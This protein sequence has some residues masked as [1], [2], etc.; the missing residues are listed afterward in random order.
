[1]LY[2][3]QVYSELISNSVVEKCLKRPGL[4]RGTGK[5]VLE[6][7]RPQ[8]GSG[9][10]NSWFSVRITGNNGHGSKQTTYLYGND[11]AQL[12]SAKGFLQ[13][14][15]LGTLHT[16]AELYKSGF[17]A[18]HG[19]VDRTRPPVEY[20]G[21]NLGLACLSKSGEKMHVFNEK[22]FWLPSPLST[23]L[24]CTSSQL[25]RRGFSNYYYAVPHDRCACLILS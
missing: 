9:S 12:I 6:K 10:F 11:T 21:K 5:V 24:P 3:C 22:S 7:I 1:M 13:M 15:G 20:T 4:G 16:F 18:D 17:S 23:M 14:E 2:K 8:A 19:L 25:K